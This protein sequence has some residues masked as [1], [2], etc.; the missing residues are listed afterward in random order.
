[1]DEVVRKELRRIMM[2]I[3][4]RLIVLDCCDD[5]DGMMEKR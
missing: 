4:D 3:E 5:E 1:V 2:L